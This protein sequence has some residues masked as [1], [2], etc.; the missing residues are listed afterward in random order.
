MTVLFALEP[1]TFLF[2]MH[3]NQWFNMTSGAAN[4]NLYSEAGIEPGLNG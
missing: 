2:S 3:V 1:Y 4:Q